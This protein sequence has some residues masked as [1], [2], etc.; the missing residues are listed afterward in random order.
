MDIA[1]IV[2]AAYS[3]YHMDGDSSMRWICMD[4]DH[5]VGVVWMVIMRRGCCMDGDRSIRW[6]LHRL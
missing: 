1:C 6:I 5:E 3:G 4:G 2:I